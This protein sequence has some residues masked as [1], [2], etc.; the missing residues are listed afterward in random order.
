MSA[1]TSWPMLGGSCCSTLS[2]SSFRGLGPSKISCSSS[3]SICACASALPLA[4]ARCA[5]ASRASGCSEERFKA[6]EAPTTTSTASERDRSFRI[7]AWTSS[8]FCWRSLAATACCAAAGST[9]AFTLGSSTAGKCALGPDQDC[10]GLKS[11]APRQVVS[12]STHRCAA[13]WVASFADGTLHKMYSIVAMMPQM[14]RT[15]LPAASSHCDASCLLG[16]IGARGGLSC[17]V[18]E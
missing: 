17:G 7:A 1:S 5:D 13:T 15:L 12:A 6:C 14:H 4:L 3:L 9:V 8:I 18:M 10:G 16:R 11:S 2:N